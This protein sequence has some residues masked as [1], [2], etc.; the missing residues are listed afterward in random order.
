MPGRT[1]R[2]P[3]PSPAR[4]VWRHWTSPQGF[5][6][7][8]IAVAALL[9][10]VIPSG[11]AV[12]LTG[13]GL[14]CPEW[15]HCEDSIVPAAD[16]HAW[17]EFTNRVFSA[18]II[19]LAIV[20]W[21]AA[22]RLPG[23]PVRLRRPA[24]ASAA[25]TVGQ[26]PLGA[27]TVAYDLHPLLVACHFALSVLAL[28]AGVVLALRAHDA[29]RGVVRGTDRGLG[30]PGAVT[31]AALAVVIATGM[32]VTA[33]GPHSGDRGVLDRIWALD[34][35]AYVHVRAVI[36]F[37]ALAALLGAL[38][39]RRVRAGLV[40]DRATRVTLAAAAP[41][42]GAQVALGEIQYRSGLPW[43]V[44]LVHVGVAGL[45]WIAALV[46]AYRL[47]RPAEGQERR[48]ARDWQGT[49]LSASGSASSRRSGM[50]APQSTQ[51]P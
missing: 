39:W 19:L 31:A 14:G 6:S 15:P 24:L 40:L 49:H 20:A 44:I 51:S 34:E 12:R 26:I 38:I 42:I 16:H 18:A 47:A 1:A 36:A 33:S 32:L 23:R 2:L 45:L 13:S 27:V 8:A 17:I 7:L 21:F 3:L 43:G 5:R 48:S 37:G 25:M 28:S 29:A 30:V 11:A 22:R 46:A 4:R 9:W 41:L 10:A 50:G 35:A